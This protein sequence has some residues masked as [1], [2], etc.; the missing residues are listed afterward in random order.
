MCS[1]T[2]KCSL[3]TEIAGAITS[4]LEI[5]R[6]ICVCVCVSKTFLHI[7]HLPK[8]T[9][10]INNMNCNASSHL[11]LDAFF[12][13]NSVTLYSTWATPLTIASSISKH[14]YLFS[15]ACVLFRSCVATVSNSLSTRKT[16]IYFQTLLFSSMHKIQ[17]VPFRI[18]STYTNNS[19]PR[20][21]TNLAP[22]FR[23][24]NYLFSS[25]PLLAAIPGTHGMKGV[26][27]LHHLMI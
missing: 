15:I 3:A 18:P 20:P 8:L 16:R 9:N 21:I 19:L 7:H 14:L 27:E 11:P 6:Y 10:S 12:L 2:L 23:G 5:E 26:S 25:L 4:T 1:H 17:H 13:R 24:K 22:I